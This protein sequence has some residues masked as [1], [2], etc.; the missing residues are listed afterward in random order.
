MG[1]GRWDLVIL[2]TVVVAAVFTG[3]KILYLFTILDKIDFHRLVS[4]WNY[5]SL[6]MSGGFVFYGGLITGVAAF[7]IC[8]RILRLNPFPLAERLFFI[9]P[10]S[11]AFGRVGC[12]F[13]GCCY[14]IE[15]SG[16]LHVVDSSGTPRFPVQLVEAFLL[17]VLAFVMYV[18]F[19]RRKR[20]GQ[21]SFY[22]LSYCVMRF[23][24][25]FFRGDSERGRIGSLSVSQWISIVLC[26]LVVLFDSYRIIRKETVV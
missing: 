3:A 19:A 16:P 11:H 21:I 6:L 5:F 9:V 1:Y 8:G 4:D 23:I 12:F 20:N 13:A 7:F 15:Y 2:E 26:L 18:L 24:L 14:G 22:F 25:E 17:L 10:L